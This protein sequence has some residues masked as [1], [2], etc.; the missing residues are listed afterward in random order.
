VGSYQYSREQPRPLSH[1]R[2]KP[3]VI[4]DER[5]LFEFYLLNN[6][7]FDGCAS[8]ANAKRVVNEGKDRLQQAIR[9]KAQADRPAT[10][11]EDVADALATRHP[12]NAETLSAEL[13]ALFDAP[14][15]R[16]NYLE[17]QG[18]HKPGSV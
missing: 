17:L 12:A 1:R 16:K 18:V 6:G 10:L 9:L 13:L 8:R 7:S 5:S 11:L 14:E 15:E 3:D 2:G 4:G